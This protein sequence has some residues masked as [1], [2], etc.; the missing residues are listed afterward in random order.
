[1]QQLTATLGYG[2]FGNVIVARREAKRPI[3]IKVLP[4][5]GAARSPFLGAPE[6]IADDLSLSRETV[7][8]HINAIFSRREPIGRTNSA[9]LVFK[10][11]LRPRRLRPL[12]KDAQRPNSKPR[13]GPEAA[14]PCRKPIDWRLTE[15]R[16]MLI[17]NEISFQAHCLGGCRSVS[18]A[19]SARGR[20]L[21]VAAT[22]HCSATNRPQ[23]TNFQVQADPRPSPRLRL[24]DR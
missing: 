2:R 22:D 6:E 4:V 17:C 24:P 11:R 23:E 16:A 13:R 14:C 18:V 15:N 19:G 3:V 1:M 10:A 12:R 21:N 5:H 20:D 8:N 9:A 7:R